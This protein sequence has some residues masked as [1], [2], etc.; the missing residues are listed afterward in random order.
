VELQPLVAKQQDAVLLSNARINL[1]EGAV[2][3]S[4]TICSLL[5]FLDFLRTGPAGPALVVGKTERTVARN[6]LD[7]LVGMLGP[8]R[9]RIV[10]G[11]GEV[12]ILGRRVYIVGANDERSSEKIRGLSLVTGYCDE[13]STIPESFWAMFLTRLSIEGA[14]AFAS[15]NPAGPAHWLKVNYLDRARLH[16]DRD[17]ELHRF[18]DDPER[19]DLHRFSFQL[20]DNPS[21]PP[22]YVEAISREFSGLLHRRLVLGEWCMA[23][24]LVY[25]MFDEKRHVIRGPLPPMIR[26]PGVGVD[27]GTVNPTAA[28]MLGIQ[29]ADPTAGTP[30]RLVL[31]REYWFDSKKALVQKTDAELSR[32]L[33]AWLGNERPQWVAVDPSAASFKLQLF[34]DGLPNVIDAKNAVLDGIRLMSSLLATNQLVIHESCTKL[35]RELANYS[36]DSKA[37]EKGH[38]KPAKINDHAADAGRYVIAS[39]ETLWRPFVPSLVTA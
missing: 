12:W 4:K 19:L 6:L 16:L 27:V 35:I 33:R 31:M 26:V 13:L 21:L 39:T 11:S 18:D 24:G 2:R 7:P 14:R 9:C 38:D 15:S 20:A 28:L 10:S 30:T 34:R 32:D 22:A 23:E 36:W 8:K 37:A 5:A 3:S 29:Q 25:D 1:Y 17:G